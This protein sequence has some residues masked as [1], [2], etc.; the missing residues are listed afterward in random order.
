MINYEPLGLV[1]IK[2][3]EWLTPS[4]ERPPVF[5][6]LPCGVVFI[7]LKHNHSITCQVIAE[8]PVKEYV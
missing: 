3:F 7:V 5:S 2:T 6:Q 1:F 8:L 4:A